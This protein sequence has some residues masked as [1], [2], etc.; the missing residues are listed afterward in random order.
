M[1]TLQYLK[2]NYPKLNLSEMAMEDLE[3]SGL[4]RNH[5]GT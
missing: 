5:R 3:T 4:W 1:N 2:E